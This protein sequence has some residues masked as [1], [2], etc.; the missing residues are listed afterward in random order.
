MFAMVGVFIRVASGLI[1]LVYSVTIQAQTNIYSIKYLPES[2]IE[3][4][5]DEIV[6][7]LNI[8]SVIG[9]YRDFG[10]SLSRMG[11]GEN[12]F[13]LGSYRRSEIHLFDYQNNVPID[14]DYLYISWILEEVTYKQFVVPCYS[15]PKYSDT[16][17]YMCYI[18][19]PAKVNEHFCTPLLFDGIIAIPKFQSRR[20]PFACDGLRII[21][22]YMLLSDIPA[23]FDKMNSED[24]QNYLTLRYSNYDPQKVRFFTHNDSWE[25]H[26]FSEKIRENYIVTVSKTDGGMHE[27]VYIDL[28]QTEESR[29]DDIIKK[30]VSFYG[31]RN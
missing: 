18:Y 31:Y 10:D 29:K 26:F 11:W 27:Q 5:K 22:G 16:D 14:T 23:S 17:Q 25:M 13:L 12:P 1:F 3:L 30:K 7:Q 21:S 2:Q 19:G 24:Q 28:S 15:V 6:K 8:Y 20:Y 9:M 4:I